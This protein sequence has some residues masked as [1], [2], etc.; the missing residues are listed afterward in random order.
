[1]LMHAALRLLCIQGNMVLT[2][3]VETH[4][5]MICSPPPCKKEYAADTLTASVKVLLGQDW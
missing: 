4:A 2:V 1:M 3:L 5:F